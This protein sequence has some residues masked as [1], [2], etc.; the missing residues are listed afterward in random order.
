MVS[1]FLDTM[2]GG[3]PRPCPVEHGSC[4][5]EGAA[6]VGRRGACPGKE[7]GGQGPPGHAARV[8]LD[9]ILETLRLTPSPPLP[10]PS[11]MGG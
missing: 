4:A 9:L 7:L 8:L 5:S 2:L 1:S 3:C 6:Q 10:F 11:P